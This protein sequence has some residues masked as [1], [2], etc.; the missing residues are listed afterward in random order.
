MTIEELATDL[1]IDLATANPES[2]TKVRTYFAE[3]A[4]QYRTATELKEA[5]E[6]NLRKV[7]E[8]QDAINTYIEQYGASEQ[9]NAALRANYAA[10]EAQLKSLKE[11]GIPV[12]IPTAPVSPAAKLPVAN[13]FDPDKFA[14]RMGSVVSQSIDASNKYLA[15][16]G[17]PMPDGLEMLAAEA[18]QARKSVGQYA[19][20]KYDFAGEE[21]RKADVAAKAHDESVGAAAVKKYQEDHPNTAGNPFMNPGSESRHPQILKPRDAKDARSFAN[22]SPREKIAQSVARSREAIAANQA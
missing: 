8:E 10:M 6:A 4:T 16:F 2:V 7:Q 21:K 18:R 20:E 22:L 15:L 5:S 13:T 1:G 11:Q 19:A 9:T 17:K 14:D 12:E 3:A